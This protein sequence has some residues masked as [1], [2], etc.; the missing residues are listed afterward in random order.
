M[1]N[2]LGNTGTICKKKKKEMVA[3]VQVCD[4]ALHTHP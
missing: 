4:D 2:Q 1:L 3:E